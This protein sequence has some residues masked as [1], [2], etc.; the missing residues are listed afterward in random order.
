MLVAPGRVGRVRTFGDA[1]GEIRR[2]SGASIIERRSSRSLVVVAAV[3]L[4]LLWWWCP[5]PRLGHARRRPRDVQRRLGPLQFRHVA[6]LPGHEA[7]LPAQRL[8]REVELEVHDLALLGQLLALAA[9]AVAEDVLEPVRGTWF[10]LP[11]RR[12]P[13]TSRRWRAFARRRRAQ[14]IRHRGDAVAGTTSRQGR[15]RRTTATPSRRHR[16]RNDGAATAPRR[17]PAP[18]GRQFTPVHTSSHQRHRAAAGNA[19]AARR[20][21]KAPHHRELKA[22]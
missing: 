20:P 8:G 17:A 1:V 22:P 15:Q 10:L 2:Q 16:H 14:V 3:R 18:R 13:G 6:L 11:R 9:V 21:H 7:A 5:G 4:P 19:F 12:R